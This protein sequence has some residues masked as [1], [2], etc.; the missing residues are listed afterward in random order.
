MK[1]HQRVF[2][3]AEKIEQ[4]DHSFNFYFTGQ[5][6]RPPLNKLEGL[7]REVNELMK[8]A[9]DSK[10]SAERFLAMQIISRFTV[11][12]TKWEKGVLDIEEGRAKQGLHFFGGF[13]AARSSMDDIKHAADSLA[14]KDIDAF[15]TSAVIDEAAERYVKLCKEHTGKNYTKESVA[16]MLEKKIEDVKKKFGSRF[17]FNVLYE[18]GKV[19]IKPEKE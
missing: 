14:K 15:R 12:K 17:K 19:V 5:E 7:K 3:L 6:K 9:Q 16:S 8:T 18:D 2:Q 11:Y 4:L 13:G 10:N 1:F